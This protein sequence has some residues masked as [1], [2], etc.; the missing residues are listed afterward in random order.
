MKK[1]FLFSIFIM[2]FFSCS[3]GKKDYTIE[4]DYRSWKRTTNIELDY[5]IP[6]HGSAYR[7][8]YINPTGENVKIEKKGN[9]ES[10]I[11]PEGTVIV[12]E[13]FN[14][15]PAGEEKADILTAMIKAPNDPNSKNGWVWI[16]QR[17]NTATIITDPFCVTCHENANESHPYGDGNPGAVFRDFVFF[18]Y[19]P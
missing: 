7:R 4:D 8:I 18:P 16:M 3:A 10:Y 9:W 11:Y 17:G 14:K 6:G 13:I 5:P 12:K 15:K 2:L 19:N 1:L